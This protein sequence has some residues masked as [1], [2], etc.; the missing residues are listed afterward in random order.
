MLG[1]LEH[2]AIQGM[3]KEICYSIKSLLGDLVVL[4]KTAVPTPDPETGFRGYIQVHAAEHADL[5]A[6]HTWK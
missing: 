2:K 1:L 3:T 6:C 4:Y 5:F